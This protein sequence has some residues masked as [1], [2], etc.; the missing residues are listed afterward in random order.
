M[1]YN[2]RHVSLSIV[3]RIWD[4]HFTLL[5]LYEWNIVDTE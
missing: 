2:I 5:L 3:P 4:I 1:Y